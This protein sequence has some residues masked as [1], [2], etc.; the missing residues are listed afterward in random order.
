MLGKKHESN[1]FREYL[2]LRM[3]GEQ[4]SDSSKGNIDEV[5]DMIGW[6]TTE[7]ISKIPKL[8]KCLQNTIFE[9]V[10]WGLAKS[11]K[12]VIM[13]ETIV[14]E[15]EETEDI[16]DGETFE[17]SLP[18][19]HYCTEVFYNCRKH[20]VISSLPE[21]K[22]DIPIHKAILEKINDECV[23]TLILAKPEIEE[24]TIT[25]EDNASKTAL[26]SRAELKRMRKKI[27]PHPL[28]FCITCNKDVCK[29]CFTTMC[30]SHN[31]VWIGNSSFMCTS[32]YHHNVGQ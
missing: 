2:E 22:L 27:I 25:V 18:T 8:E 16:F 14:L 32:L 23:D 12:P 9:W 1:D 7:Y 3:K 4:H 24:A 20:R 17:L 28:Y 15:D 29:D 5:E 11:T 26:T 30:I 10:D 31:V 6:N 19:F 21:T 13:F